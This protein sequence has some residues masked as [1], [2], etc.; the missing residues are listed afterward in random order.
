MLQVVL[1][2]SVIHCV[3][4]AFSENT[5]LVD[6]HIFIPKMSL[7]IH[8]HQENVLLNNFSEQT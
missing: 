2:Y 5:G 3:Q 1:S 4:C 8:D 7:N 6:V